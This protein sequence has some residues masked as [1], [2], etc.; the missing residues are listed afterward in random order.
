VKAQKAAGATAVSLAVRMDANV[1]IGPDTF[2][3]REAASGTRPELVVV[4]ATS[5]DAPPTVATAAA[6]SPNPVPGTTTSL[7][8]LGADDGGEPALLY[9]WTS[10][11][12]APV[13]FSSNGNN[14]AKNTTATFSQ[15]GAYTLTATIRDVSNQTVTSAVTVNVNQTLTTIAVT[16]ASASVATGGTQQFTATARDQF[17]I[18]LATQPSFSWMVSG[19]GSISATGLFSAGTL[20]EVPSWSPPR[21][22]ASAA[23]RR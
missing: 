16:P 1:T 6:A 2:G 14:A 3:S 11:G 17:S 19:G 13:S 15:A 8:V 18:A 12:P 10:M 7:S 5:V 21:A 4:F 22:A 20:P 23:R 9:T